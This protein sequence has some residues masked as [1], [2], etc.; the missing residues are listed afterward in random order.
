[1]RRSRRRQSAPAR[2]LLLAAWAAVALVPIELGSESLTLESY[3]PSPLGIYSNLTSTGDTF[4]ARDGGKVGVGTSSPQAGLDVNGIVKLGTY[5][6]NPPASVPG[7]VAGGIYYDTQQKQVYANDG[8]AWKAVGG[9][10]G[11]AAR[12]SFKGVVNPPLIFNSYNVASV[13]YLGTGTYRVNFSTPM[14]SADY[15]VSAVSSGWVGWNT[16][17]CGVGQKQFGNRTSSYIDIST[18]DTP[19]GVL[20]AYDSGEVDVV[21]YQ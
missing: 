13:A 20:T 3:Y 6:G 19:G 21:V 18:C 5:G 14:N 4:L 8:S 1:M 11:P 12:V 16:W 7:A 15:V 17:V 2:R 10:S 9:N